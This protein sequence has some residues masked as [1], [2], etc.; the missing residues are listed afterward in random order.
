M[1]DKNRRV[2]KWIGAVIIPEYRPQ[3]GESPGAPERSPSAA[4]LKRFPPLGLIGFGRRMPDG[5][6]IDGLEQL[7][8]ELVQSAYTLTGRRPFVCA[9]L[10]CGAGYHLPGASLLP[11]ARALAAAEATLPGA[12]AAAA[13]LT[14]REARAAGIDLVLA[15]VLDVN[16]N[17]AN[18][19]IGVR[20]FGRTPGEVTTMGRAF[21]EGLQ[22]AGAGACIKH[23]PGH[24]DTHQDSHLTLPTILRSA[25]QLEHCELAPFRSVLADAANSAQGGALAV[26]VAHLDVP[27]LTGRAGLVT[28]LSSAVMDGL[29]RDGFEGVAMTDGLAMKAVSDLADLGARSLA[30]GCD[31][32]LAPV[33]EETMAEQLLEAV[34]AGRLSEQRLE[35]AAS[36]MERLRGQLAS[37]PVPGPG[38]ILPNPDQLARAALVASPE[39]DRWTRDFS[40][41]PLHLIGT[42]DFEQV[43]RGLGA[44]QLAQAGEADPVLV[45]AGSQN[46]MGNGASGLGPAA[47]DQAMAAL[48]EARSSG[49]KAGFVWFGAPEGLLGEHLATFRAELAQSKAPTLVAFAP[50]DLMVRAVGDLLASSP[51]NFPG[52]KS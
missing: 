20:A 17:P 37:A 30:A 32:L 39:S 42:S 1:S 4:Y 49:R 46:I 9:D 51:D 24:G 23:Y 26:M 22:R 13:E 45:V 7:T 31:A 38:A 18:P 33:C 19:I 43:A 44:A 11:P 28:S 10:E 3:G 47:A 29:R 40:G 8:G 48:R 6:R 14:G 27:A 52:D 34:L 21:V 35:Q 15:P 25:E 2:E 50:S 12:V 16:T 41:K 36:R 5:L